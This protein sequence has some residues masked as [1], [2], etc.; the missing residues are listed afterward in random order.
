MKTFSPHSAASSEFFSLHSA[1]SGE[2]IS[3]TH[4]LWKKIH[5]IKFFLK[6]SSHWAQILHFYTTSPQI[7]NLWAIFSCKTSTRVDKFSLG[8]KGAENVIQTTL[9]IS[10]ILFGF[11]F[12]VWVG[13]VH[14]PELLC[15]II[16]LMA[17]NL[18]PSPHFHPGF[19]HWQPSETILDTP[20]HE[21]QDLDSLDKTWITLQ[22]SLKD[23]NFCYVLVRSCHDLI[24]Q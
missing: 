24:K 8:G 5:R 21:M 9:F 19:E 18:R 10:K 2:K 11:T 1:G 7:L 4:K 20:C 14:F 3:I 16:W 15:S 13:Y 23:K 12:V 6:H 22:R 17:F